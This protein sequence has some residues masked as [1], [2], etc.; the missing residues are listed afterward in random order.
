MKTKICA[1]NL[2]LMLITT[3]CYNINDVKINCSDPEEV[4]HNTRITRDEYAKITEY[5][6]PDIDVRYHE[7]LFL[8][9][10]KD[11]KNRTDYQ[12]YIR[13]Y[14]RGD[15]RG[16]DYA[17]DSYGKRFSVTYIDS[18]IDCDSSS[19]AHCE[20]VGVNISKEDLVN[21]LE[22]GINLKLYS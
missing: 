16:Y 18:D 13:T 22:S 2:I 5:I 4:Y 11:S 10:W 12:I 15:Y 6:G 9:A 21:S 20:D 7:N 1:T 19:C 3:G 8:R 14:Y 17:Y